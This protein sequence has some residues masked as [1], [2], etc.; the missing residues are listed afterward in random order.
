MN[1]EQLV[2][3]GLSE[4]QADQVLGLLK[5][6]F[7]PMG[8][9]NELNEEAKAAKETTAERDKQLEELKKSTGDT[10]A[11]KKQIETLQADNKT[12]EDTYKA[13]IQKVK[14]DN[15]LDLAL[16]GSKAKNIKT[17]KALL[18]VEKLKLKD[19]GSLDGLN[20]QIEA[21]KKTDSY[22]FEA[23]KTVTTPKG[24]VPGVAAPEGT[25]TP[26]N[27]NGFKDAI[28]AAFNKN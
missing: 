24:Y 17:I 9:F 26:P 25:T 2:K 10:E 22:L 21:I 15:A 6:N 12:K 18:D 5:D 20:D 7:V 28:A 11:L 1:K 23:E 27:N 14:F 16:T 19:D 8:R 3:M 4:A 13:E